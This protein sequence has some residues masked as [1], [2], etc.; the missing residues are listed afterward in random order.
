[1]QRTRLSSYRSLSLHLKAFYLRG[2]LIHS[3]S[4]S[5]FS[6]PQS[7]FLHFYIIGVVVNTV[8]LF[9]ATFYAYTLMASPYLPCMQFST[10]FGQL[11]HDTSFNTQF[12]KK[13]VSTLAK[14]FH[15][16]WETVFVLLLMEMQ[17]V[18]RLYESLCVS[19]FSGL[20]RMHIAAYIFGL[21][22]YVL[23]PLSLCSSEVGE[24]V[25]STIQCTFH[26]NV[27]QGA[28]NFGFDMQ[29][30]ELIFKMVWLPWIGGAFFIWGWIHQYKCHTILASLRSKDKS[31]G[32]H[33]TGYMVPYGDWFD[34]VSSAH[35]LAEIVMYLGLVI[36][37][38]GQLTVWLLFTFVVFN[39]SVAAVETHKWYLSKFEDYPRSRWAICPF[40]F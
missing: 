22:Y 23:A 14:K 21:M 36:A 26:K 28:N 16:A 25:M 18:R 33:A 3:S 30:V 20:A 12:A 37:T 1:M 9:T 19:N 5:I 11:V 31:K 29:W 24:M 2:K 13:S 34:C 32:N 4:P 10:L 6:V 8:L 7:Y 27:R 39:L 38:G 15:L 17:V 40:L 35:Y